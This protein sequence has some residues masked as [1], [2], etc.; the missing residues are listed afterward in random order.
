M[1]HL[2]FFKHFCAIPDRNAQPKSLVGKP[3]NN[4]NKKIRLLHTKALA[5][6]FFVATRIRDAIADYVFFIFR[7]FLA[8]AWATSFTT[9]RQDS[10]MY[11][12]HELKS[13][14]LAMERDKRLTCHI[15]SSTEGSSAIH[16]YRL[17]KVRSIT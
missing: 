15:R 10:D 12:L 6:L 4:E 17:S 11:F 7:K 5:L 1:V 16:E 8:F 14:G 2:K 3:I 13:I 9:V